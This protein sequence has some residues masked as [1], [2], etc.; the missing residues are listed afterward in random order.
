M[1]GCAGY[2]G[3]EWSAALAATAAQGLQLR[4]E[5]GEGMVVAHTEAAKVHLVDPRGTA[6]SEEA[7]TPPCAG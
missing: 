7:P 5:E 1:G 6:Q 2:S 3:S 4:E